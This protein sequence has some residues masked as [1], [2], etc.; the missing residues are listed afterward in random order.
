MAANPKHVGQ[1]CQRDG[2]QEVG[3]NPAIRFNNDTLQI[4]TPWSLRQLA[5][6][7]LGDYVSLSR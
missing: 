5:K 3:Q 4:L 6:R 1:A 2:D 7:S